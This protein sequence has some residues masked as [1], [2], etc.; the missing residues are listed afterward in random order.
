M[1]DGVDH[2][3][4]AVGPEPNKPQ[5][6]SEALFDF[7]N[8]RYEMHPDLSLCTERT[9]K[10]ASF[11]RGVYEEGATAECL[12]NSGSDF[13]H[14]RSSYLAFD[15]NIS[16][17]SEASNP[18]EEYLHFGKSG[19]A[20][21]LIRR[22]VITDRGGNEMERLENV[23]ALINALNNINQSEGFFNTYATQFQYPRKSYEVLSAHA[24]PPANANWRQIGH[25]PNG[26]NFWGGR[27]LQTAIP[28]VDK[29]LVFYGDATGTSG[30]DTPSIMSMFRINEFIRINTGSSFPITTTYKIVNIGWEVGYSFPYL[31]LDKSLVGFPM[32]GED[33]LALQ[34]QMFV[35]GSDVNTNA[36]S[37]TGTTSWVL[38]MYMMSGLFDVKKL[39]PSNLMS[40]VKIQITFETLD[41]AFVYGNRDP[42]AINTNPIW[43]YTISNCRFILD[44]CK[45][46]DMAA[47][48]LTTQAATSGLELTYR[49]WFSTP[50][51]IQNS[52][53]VVIESRKAVSRAFRAITMC[54]ATR[55]REENKT[56]SSLVP[57]MFDYTKWQY[58]AGNLYFPNQ[59]A[60]TK[61]S[62]G[63]PIDLCKETF[64]QTMRLFEKHDELWWEPSQSAERWCHTTV[65]QSIPTGFPV[66][67]GRDISEPHQSQEY[68]Y[69]FDASDQ[70]VSFAML[71]CDLERSE[72]Q[73]LSGIPLN[74]SRVLALEAEVRTPGNYTFLL[75]MQHLKVARIFVDNSEIEE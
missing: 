52:N 64:S 67:V 34:N 56:Q 38:P 66:V 23:N 2:G 42:E 55:T 21:N 69:V 17:P 24:S 31:V 4:Q 7:N 32:N 45:L 22:I 33:P 26:N 29:K 72:V 30:A 49:T 51:Q 70:N 14:G 74:N 60:T 53:N 59:F 37:L 19:S 61:T 36:Y 40:G 6:S 62:L 1:N 47:R 75:F 71:P 44:S 68:P 3:E 8:L 65:S 57:T 10:Q 54:Y 11:Q 50:T 58:R 35:T 25:L 9:M 63:S 46:S 5:D 18:N 28:D 27:S 15:L 39:L 12:L 16:D 48:A 73:D 13:I 43:K 20:F 41:N